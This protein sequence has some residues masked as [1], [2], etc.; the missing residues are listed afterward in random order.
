MS[1]AMD[2]FLTWL[3]YIK[4]LIRRACSEVNVTDFTLINLKLYELSGISK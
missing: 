2:A 1:V 3:I 4:D